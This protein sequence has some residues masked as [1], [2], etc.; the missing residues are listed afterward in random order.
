MATTQLPRLPLCNPSG[1]M[2]T[3]SCAIYTR[4]SSE[5][6]LEQDFNSLHAQREACEAFI[7]SQKG[8]GWI[9]MP[10]AYDDGGFSGGNVARPGLQHLIADIEAGKVNVIVVYKVDRLTRSL[11]DFAK[12]VELFDVYRVSFVSVTQQFNTT[13]S[14]GRLTLNVLLSF[15]Q[16]EREVTGERIRDKIAASKRKGIWMGGVPPVGYLAHNRTLEP[17]EPYAGRVA[18]IYRLYL[19]LNCVRKV[20]QELQSRGWLTRERQNK[21]V[22]FGGNKPFSRGHL[23]RILANPVYVG[24]LPHQGEN[25]PGQH[26][27]IVDQALWEAVQQRLKSNRQGHKTRAS[28]AGP[29]LLVGKLFDEMGRRLGPTHTKKGDRRYRYY[30]TAADQPGEP[31][32]MP[33]DDLERQVIKAIGDWVED[34]K[35]LLD[36]VGWKEAKPAQ[37][38]ILAAKQ[39]GYELQRRSIPQLASC[40]SRVEIAPDKVLIT[41][42]LVACGIRPESGSGRRERAVIEV[43][44]KRRRYGTAVRLVIDGEKPLSPQ[45]QPDPTLVALVAKGRAWLHQ[46]TREGKSIKEISAEANYSERYVNRVINIALLSPDILARLERGHHPEGLSGTRLLTTVPFPERWEEQRK[47]LGLPT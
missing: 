18:E 4:K 46:F 28:Q 26:P 33:A 44:D 27:G 35:R 16:F 21:R 8:L 13:T 9:L 19:Q 31:I 17:E 39:F 43:P 5:E 30:A 36:A 40:I 47:A 34:E 22:G 14:M 3:L 15:A 12:L 1:E 7:L 37:E 10:D 42:D 23:Y 29:S 45:K 11:A 38:A 41:L 24:L 25:Y 20:A 2:P 6:G 32:R